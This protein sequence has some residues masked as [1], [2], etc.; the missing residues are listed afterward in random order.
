MDPFPGH[1]D[2]GVFRVYEYRLIEVSVSKQV[3]YNNH[4]PVTCDQKGAGML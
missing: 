2:P 4:S 3:A 1:A